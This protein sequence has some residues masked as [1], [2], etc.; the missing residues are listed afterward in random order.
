MARRA[1]AASARSVVPNAEIAAAL[2]EL[3]DALEIEG[4]N[5]F[6]VRAYRA[7]AQ[8]VETLGRP[9]AELAAEGG[10]AALEA[11]PGIGESLAAKIVELVSTG[12]LA[13]LRQA[14]RR[15]PTSLSALLGIPGL[16]PKRLHQL[17]DELGVR[18]LAGLER[19]LAHGEI[20]ALAGFGERSAEKL[21]RGVEAFRRRSGRFLLAAAEPW[22]EAL[23]ARLAAAEGTRRVEVAGSY[24]RRKETVGDLDLL[25][26]TRRPAAAA[27]AFVGFDAVAEVTARGPTRVAVRLRNGLAVD[28]RLVD[29]AA[30][31]AALVYFTG[32]KEHNL[33]LRGMAREM[34]LKVNEYGVFRGRRRLAGREER[35]VYAVFDAAWIPPELRENHD[36]IELARTGRLPRLLE[37]ADLRGDLQMHTDATDGRATAREMAAAARAL[38]HAYVAITDHSRAVRVAG[39]LDDAAMRKHARAL[40]RIAVPG[41]RVLAGVEVDILKDGTLDL[42]PATLRGLDLVVASVHSALEQDEATMTKRVIAAIDSGLVHVL[43]HPTGRLLGEREPIA[44]DLPAVVAACVRRGV[45]LEINAHPHRLD[46]DD[47]HTRMAREMGARLVISTDAHSTDELAL[48]RFGVDVARRAGLER[49]DVLNTLPAEKLLAVLGGGRRRPLESKR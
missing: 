45:A 1:P 48:L 40:R 32:S 17:H 35:D 20:A 36:E 5:P 21:R 24:R 15:V 6:R 19:A 18:D 46:L 13:Q 23:R 37:L 2:R 38:G 28:L 10:A 8:T 42:A 34:G 7:G 25:C 12:G 43:G 39:G 11:L 4:A 16:G 41:L 33:V 26:S 3:A 9:L 47:V 49:R 30:F 44:I 22:A 14:R 31:G 27:A 29:D